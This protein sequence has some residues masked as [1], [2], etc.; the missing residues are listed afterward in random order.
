MHDD[1]ARW[2]SAHTF[3]VFL[4]TTAKI[5]HLER[6]PPPT[7]DNQGGSSRWGLVCSVEIGLVS[8]DVNV[9]HHRGWFVLV[10]HRILHVFDSMVR[11][12][13]LDK[14]MLEFLPIHVRRVYQSHLM[15][16]CENENA[17]QAYVPKDTFLLSTNRSWDSPS[18]RIPQPVQTSMKVHAPRHF[19]HSVQLEAQW[20]YPPCVCFALHSQDRGHVPATKM[21]IFLFLYFLSVFSSISINIFSMLF[22]VFSVCISCFFNN[23][24]VLQR[25]IQWQ[26]HLI[27]SKFD[28]F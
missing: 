6:I 26:F 11:K 19:L 20:W 24:G 13:I 12:R 17:S 9:W 8:S 16:T 28:S 14:V 7:P 3:S 21:N 27:L 25:K 22:N 2:W 4:I 18:T 5:N 15:T 10:T 1:A 23:R